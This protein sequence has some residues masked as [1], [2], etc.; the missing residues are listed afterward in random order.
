MY[1]HKLFKADIFLILLTIGGIAYLYTNHRI[2]LSY[3]L[4][5]LTIYLFSKMFGYIILPYQK[6]EIFLSHLTQTSKLP[7]LSGFEIFKTALVLLLYIGFIF[8][9]PSF[10]IVESILVVLMRIWGKAFIENQIESK[11]TKQP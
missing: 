3:S 9:H 2:S 4:I 7:I 1:K 11:Q 8:I 6:F 5:V 10:W